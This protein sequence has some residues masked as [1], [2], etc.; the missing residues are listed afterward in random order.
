MIHLEKFTA[1]LKT[2]WVKR[3]TFDNLEDHW[4]DLVDNNMGINIKDRDTLL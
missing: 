3:Y 2:S 1:S 4:A